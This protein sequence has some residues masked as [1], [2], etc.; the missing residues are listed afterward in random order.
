MR[1]RINEGT[2]RG[3]I[4][5]IDI[6]PL[7]KGDN[8]TLFKFIRNEQ[9]FFAKMGW[10]SGF[11][12]GGSVLVPC[13]EVWD[14]IPPKSFCEDDCYEGRHPLQKGKIYNAEGF[15]GMIKPGET[16]QQAI[17]RLCAEANEQEWANFRNAIHNC[18]AEVLS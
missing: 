1:I 4:N 18:G 6:Y 15:L 7:Q 14:I 17:A 8:K 2:D 11:G 12:I 16:S 3:I 9:G 13:P 5:F 10:E